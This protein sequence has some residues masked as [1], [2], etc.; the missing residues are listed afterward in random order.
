MSQNAAR[1][2]GFVDLSEQKEAPAQKSRRSRPLSAVLSA[3]NNPDA[4]RP[5][6]KL[7]S[8]AERAVSSIRVIPHSNL[9]EIL[10]VADLADGGQARSLRVPLNTPVVG[11]AKV[12][13]Q[14]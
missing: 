13:P 1:I 3:A 8:G 12:K 5:V 11:W 10:T 14:S 7:P 2:V 9:V 4:D 6:I